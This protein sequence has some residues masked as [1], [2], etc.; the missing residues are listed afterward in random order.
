MELT[1]PIL[2]INRHLVNYFGIDTVSGLPM[3]RVV[4]SEDQYEKRLTKYSDGGIELLHAEVRLL[5][6]YKQWI[7]NKYL[8]ERLVVVPDVNV[9]ELAA[10][11]LSYEPIYVFEDAQGNYLP[12]K[13]NGCKF[14]IDTMY[15][16]MGKSSL[17]K[18]VDDEAT[19]PDFK[20]KRVRELQAEL[21]GNETEVGTAL[22][23]GY[24]VTVPN[25]YQKES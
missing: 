1:E 20:E 25:S 5:P 22:A 15:A 17:V 4:Y 11:K 8:I 3:F 13:T 14:V 16:A 24:G 10:Q 23:H 12:P 7:Q 9:A 19:D 18:Y 2:D 6:K 21:F